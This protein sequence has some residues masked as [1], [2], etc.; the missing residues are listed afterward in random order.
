V[1]RREIPVCDQTRRARAHT[2]HVRAACR[3]LTPRDRT[4]RSASRA[5][6]I[7][8]LSWPRALF[9]NIYYKN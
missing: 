7:V 2:G 9:G 6:T 4:L 5:R 8:G 1:H 3:R